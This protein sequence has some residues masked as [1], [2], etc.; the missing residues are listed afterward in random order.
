MSKYEMNPAGTEALQARVDEVID[1]TLSKQRLVGTVVK[2][3][4]DGK[5]GYSRAA[6]LADRESKVS[7]REDSLFRLASVTKVVVSAAALVL[8]SR[9]RL[10]LD[11]PIDKWL[12]YFKPLL[13]DG[14]PAII[15]LRQLMSHTAGLNYGFLE[16][17]DGPY[18]RAG[19]SDGMDLSGLSL[20]EN[21]RRLASVPLIF[22]P[23]TAWN[24]SLATDVL[25]GIVASAHG[26]TLSEAVRSLVTEPI[27]LTDTAF[28]V[29]DPQRLAASYADDTPAPRRMREPDIVGKM[30][31]VAGTLLDPRRA[32]DPFAFPSGGAGMI[33]SADDILHL[34]E[35]LR[36]GGKPLLTP[37]LIEE[38][39]RSQ[40]SGLTLP[41]SPGWGF[42]LGFSVLTDPAAAATPQSAGTWRWGGVYG[43][44]W[45]VDPARKLTVLA[46]TNTTLEGMSG[47]FT[48]DL[49]D[50]VYE[51]LNHSRQVFEY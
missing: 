39:G 43:H 29:V 10:D 12:P 25:G 50:A 34:L 47:Q 38:M 27:G 35:T 24:Y 37:A 9:G 7:M 1:R 19:V 17:E 46:L 41:N 40:T 42:G 15:T 31:G 51:C 13:P 14:S 3:A 6:G 49:R 18:H 33:G 16:P 5:L 2:I 30:E 36:T 11:T 28:D 22:K 48:L 45:F 44:S 21:L 23:G 32:F 8:V 26:S 4:L 20:E